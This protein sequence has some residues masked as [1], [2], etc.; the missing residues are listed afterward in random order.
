VADQWNL[1]KGKSAAWIAYRLNDL[2]G[3]NF[4]DTYPQPSGQRWR[5]ETQW[6]NAAG[7]AGIAVNIAPAL[8]YGAPWSSGHIAYVELILLSTSVVI[9]EMNYDLDSG[10]RVRTITTAS[11]WRNGFIHIKDITSPP[12]PP[13]SRAQ[14]RLDGGGQVWAKTTIG[15]CGWTQE[16]PTGKTAIAAV[17]GPQMLL[18]RVDDRVSRLAIRRADGY[19]PCVPAD[20]AA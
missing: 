9:S 18:D 13:T 5:N 11:G 2:N 19:P 8:G 10:L 15:R 12:S 20:G 7:R 3:V 1:Y 6:A 17:N 16:T 4:N 14:L